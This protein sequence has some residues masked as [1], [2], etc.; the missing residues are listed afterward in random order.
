LQTG[1]L[2]D[3]KQPFPVCTSFLPCPCVF[4]DHF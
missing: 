2:H 3:L 4:L 1:L